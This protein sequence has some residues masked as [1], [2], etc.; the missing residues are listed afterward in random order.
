M[1]PGKT[2]PG[3]LMSLSLMTRRVIS[4]VRSTFRLELLQVE[5]QRAS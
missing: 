1:S 2:L 5:S 4:L 3:H